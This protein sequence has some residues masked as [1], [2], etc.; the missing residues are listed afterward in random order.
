MSQTE[1]LGVADPGRWVGVAASMAGY[2][3]SWLAE[4]GDHPPV[5]R[6]IFAGARRF[7]TQAQEGIALDRRERPKPDI[8]I[9]AGISN[10]TIALGVLH[11]LA[12]PENLAQVEEK[13]TEYLRCLQAI[14]ENGPRSDALVQQARAVKAFFAELQ[15]Q[16]NRA[17]HAAF[18]RAASPLL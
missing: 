5:P 9:M 16:G 11:H 6:G 18:A 2:L 13:F 17:R 7:L 4:E 14:E 12:P 3:Q 10:L 15:E 8:P 1:S